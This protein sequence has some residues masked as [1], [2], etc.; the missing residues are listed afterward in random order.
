LASVGIVWFLSLSSSGEEYGHAFARVTYD[1]AF[2]EDS[3]GE[4]TRSVS[5]QLRFFVKTII[6][7]QS[8]R[9]MPDSQR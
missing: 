5:I 8:F 7:A 9:W 4:L 3:D 6:F 2:W 1:T